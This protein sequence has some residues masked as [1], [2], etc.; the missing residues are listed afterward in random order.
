M[1]FGFNFNQFPDEPLAVSINAESKWNVIMWM[2]HRAGK[3]AEDINLTGHEC[4]KSVG[5]LV[6]FSILYVPPQIIMKS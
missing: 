3:E 5:E 1:E 6:Q 4:L 2:D